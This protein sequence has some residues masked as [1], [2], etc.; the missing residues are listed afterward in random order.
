MPRDI[1]DFHARWERAL[2]DRGTE[3][4]RML[5][6]IFGGHDADL[7]F[8][9]LV[10]EPPYPP[11]S[12]VVTWLAGRESSVGRLRRRLLWPALLLIVADGII[13]VA[14]NAGDLQLP[15]IGWL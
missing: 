10:P 13:G 4:V 1:E 3:S 6:R 12:F 5:V 14:V 2:E 9:S 7:P 15:N 8:R 11:R